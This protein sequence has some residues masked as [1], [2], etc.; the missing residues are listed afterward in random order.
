MRLD[1]LLL[2]L[3]PISMIAGFALTKVE[4]GEP[5]GFHGRGVPVAE[6]YWDYPP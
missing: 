5:S 2:A 1:N 6:V 3:I 4:W